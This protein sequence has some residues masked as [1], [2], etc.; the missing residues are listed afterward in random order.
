MQPVEARES[1]RIEAVQVIRRYLGEGEIEFEEP[2]VGTFVLVLPGEHRLK[3]TVL[4]TIGQ[5]AMS[6]NSFVVRNPDDNHVA[7][8]RWL[9]ERNL[10][11]YGVGYAVDHLGDVY[12]AGKTPL[13]AINDSELDRLLGS[14][15]ENSDGAF[16]HLLELGFSSAIKREWAWRISR[17]ESTK[18]L[19]AFAH[20]ADRNAGTQSAV[21]QDDLP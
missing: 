17:G 7:V 18:N 10:R 5:H 4:L 15:L 6:I 11:I 9:L 19:A 3:T 21:R 12:L 16:D 20:L 14:I 8:Y 1:S 13:H 2:V